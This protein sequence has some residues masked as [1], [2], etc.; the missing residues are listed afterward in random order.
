MTDRR[1]PLK[2][3]M[4]INETDVKDV[5]MNDDNVTDVLADDKFGAENDS[6]L[7]D[8]DVPQENPSKGSPNNMFQK[9]LP[10]FFQ[11]NLVS[12]NT[13]MLVQFEQ[14]ARLCVLIWQIQQRKFANVGSIFYKSM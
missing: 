11:V 10:G 14:M 6:R 9:P 7:F 5:A 4:F 13:A 2:N 3:V 8:D 1:T 12:F